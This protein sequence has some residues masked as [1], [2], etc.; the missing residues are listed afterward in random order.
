ME[1]KQFKQL[2]QEHFANLVDG[3]N[4]LFTA[5]INKDELWE[6]YLNSFPAGTNE[7]FR[8]RQEYD[9]SCCKQF[10]RQFGSVVA[11]DE[12]YN[13]VTIWDFLPDNDIFGP[14]MSALS[15]LVK[16][17]IVRDVFVSKQAAFGTDYNKEQFSDGTIHTWHHFRIDLPK[18]F[19]FNS[20]KSA[21]TIA[22]SYRDIKNIFRR[23]LDEISE[24]AITT[25]LDLIAEKALY[26]GEEWQRNL[27]QF[28]AL[29]QE[30]HTLSD[31]KKD[32]FCWLKS[33]ELGGAIGKIRNHSIGVLLQ[34]ITAG[35]DIAEAVRKYEAIVAPTNYKRPKAIFTTK[36]VEQAQKTITDLGLLDSLGRRHAILS[37]IT[38]NNVLWANR[39][40][41]NHM[42]GAN[43]VFEVLKQ[44]ATV[45]PKK[46]DGLPGVT[47]EEFI[48]N[49][50]PSITSLEILLENRHEP[51]FVSLIAP[52]VKN[53]PTLFKWSNNFSW[54]YNG[55][56]TDS[57]KERV[58]M[59]GGNVT[60]VL[61]NS[62]QWDNNN[63]FDLHCVEPNG[64]RIYFQTKGIT[65]PSSGMLDV[66]IIE[67]FSDGRVRDGIAVEN[68]IYTNKRKMQEGI[69]QVFVHNYNH[70]GGRSGF[71]AELEYEGQIYSYD[72]PHELRH[73]ELVQVAK[74][75]F[76]RETGIK[77]IESLP[78]TTASKT[79]WNLQT[80]QFQPVSVCMFSPNYWDGQHGIGNKHYFFMLAGCENDTQPNGFFNEYLREEFMEYKRV[81]EALGSKMKV[82]K[83]NNQL[84]GLGFSSTRRNSLI[85]K[86][87]DRMVKVV[88]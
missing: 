41:Q 8:E 51:S 34:D 56:I 20:N 12:D 11:I 77:F 49:L 18:R 37:D 19:V 63:D 6:T 17:A 66:D 10:V 54:A 50:L 53:S 55:N 57:L 80:N 61:R 28:L 46:F 29:H 7:V 75:S 39:D 78:S 13:L 48:N 33:T 36:M 84:S 65:H 4:V 88:F 52:Q 27:E 24:D 25:I 83:S 32:N 74:F 70:R 81:F 47:I 73:N 22:A 82:E 21:D 79:I 43:S 87:D 76:D 85:C 58:K 60:G 44:E 62:L 72:Y 40:A 64:N 30:Y 23:S 38:I 68:I 67:P 16:L 3:Q 1:F 15:T 2:Q 59:M 42:N 9:C 31:E 14:V 45:N 26:R 86:I 35:V 69:Y 71:Q 5:D